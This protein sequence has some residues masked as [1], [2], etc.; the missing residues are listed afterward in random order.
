MVSILYLN[1][2]LCVNGFC[3]HYI[4]LLNRLLRSSIIAVIFVHLIDDN[5]TRSYPGNYP[6]LR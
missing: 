5:G 4:N 1:N 3:V 2:L 6:W